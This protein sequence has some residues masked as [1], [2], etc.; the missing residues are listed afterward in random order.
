MHLISLQRQYRQ[1]KDVFTAVELANAMLLS[2][3]EDRAI[4]MPLD[5]AEYERALQKKITTSI[6]SAKK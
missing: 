2:S 5:G 6:R 4:E 3:F 1:T